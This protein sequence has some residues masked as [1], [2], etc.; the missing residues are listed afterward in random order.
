MDENDLLKLKIEKLELQN[1][2]LR[3]I[4]VDN[5]LT[6]EYVGEDISSAADIEDHMDIEE[7]TDQTNLRVA[8]EYL[9]PDIWYGSLQCITTPSHKI[10]LPGAVTHLTAL[11]NNN[12]IK[13]FNT[14]GIHTADSA[15]GGKVTDSC[16]FNTPGIHTADSAIGGKVTDSAIGSKAADS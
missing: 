16:S 8:N 4:L 13:S 3:R 1:A 9:L 15:I 12:K 2:K 5:N 10:F 6:Q 11:I 7:T 14:P